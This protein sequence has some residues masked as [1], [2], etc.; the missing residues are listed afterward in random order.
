MSEA[1]S[2]AT[3]VAIGRYAWQRYPIAASDRDESFAQ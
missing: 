3:T 1:A 2:S